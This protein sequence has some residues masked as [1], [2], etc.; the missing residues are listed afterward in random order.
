MS[1][2]SLE[3]LDRLKMTGCSKTINFGD[4]FHPE[5]AGYLTELEKTV[6]ISCIISLYPRRGNFS[7]LLKEL[8]IKYDCIKIPIPSPI[9]KTI[10]EKKGFL[11]VEEYQEKIMETIP[12]MIWK[13]Q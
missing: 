11:Y 10:V 3:D 4:K 8:K 9:M 7:R 12:I 1:D 13:R 2:K 6:F 5:F